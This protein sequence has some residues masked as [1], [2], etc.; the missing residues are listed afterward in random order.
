MVDFWDSRSN[1]LLTW[2]LTWRK[3]QVKIIGRIQT[4]THTRRPDPRNLTFKLKCTSV[5]RYCYSVSSLPFGHLYL[6]YTK[7]E[8]R[9]SSP[10]QE[11]WENNETCTSHDPLHKS[12][13]DQK[14]EGYP[15]NITR[16]AALRAPCQLQLHAPSISLNA[17][18]GSWEVGE[19]SVWGLQSEL[20]S[21]RKTWMNVGG[22]PTHRVDAPI[23][24]HLRTRP[25]V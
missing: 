1:A 21:D 15:W 13:A 19:Q 10:K 7:I 24:A 25:R 20:G 18:L 16:T 3:P 5:S 14:G 12:L 23:I 2:A 22:S 6:G 8:A 17:D 9:E 11:R 4:D